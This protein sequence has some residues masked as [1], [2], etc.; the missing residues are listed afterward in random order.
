MSYTDFS[1]TGTWSIDDSQPSQ[2][3]GVAAHS[4]KNLLPGEYSM[5][6]IY[7][8]VPPQG[9]V[10]SFDYHA[11]LGTFTFL[12]NDSQLLKVQT[13]GGGTKTFTKDMSAGESTLSWRYDAPQFPNLPLSMVWIDNIR[14]T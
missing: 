1:G 12:L 11:G 9:V 14:L 6:T 10:L 7:V 3:T 2:R 13:P 5:M 4:P 8:D